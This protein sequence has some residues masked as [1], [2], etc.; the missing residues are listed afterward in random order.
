MASRKQTKKSAAA[1]SAAKQPQRGGKR[2]AKAKR[3][4]RREV[5]AVVCLLLGLC[6]ALACFGI[7]APGLNVLSV[8]F[9]GLIGA[10]LY[11]LPF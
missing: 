8:L 1:R 11:I 7:D 4:I 6:A 3:P 5:G 2:A 10:G 9:R